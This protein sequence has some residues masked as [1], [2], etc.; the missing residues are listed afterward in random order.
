M[1]TVIH[2]LV[3]IIFVFFHSGNAES[4]DVDNDSNPHVLVESPSVLG[5]CSLREPMGSDPGIMNLAAFSVSLTPDSRFA[6]VT[7]SVVFEAQ[8]PDGYR[9]LG[10]MVQFQGSRRITAGNNGYVVV[11]YGSSGVVTQATIL[12]YGATSGPLTGKAPLVW[13]T[14]EECGATHTLK[15]SVT[16][17]ISQ[18]GYEPDDIPEDTRWRPD[19]TSTMTLTRLNVG[20]YE[21]EKC[22]NTN[23]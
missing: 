11:R 17:R 16:L 9:L 10:G 6:S 20:S 19:S 14:T 3:F 13:E 23:T 2:W 18:S 8:I 21:L 1:K 12:E 7:C 5:P 15:A 22:P 4:S